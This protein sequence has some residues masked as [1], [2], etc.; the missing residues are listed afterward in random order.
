[1]KANNA[2]Y[3]PA[4][5]GGPAK[6]EVHVPEASFKNNPVAFYSPEAIAPMVLRAVRNNRPFIFDHGD[7]RKAF[8]DTYSQVV[9]A[10]YDDVDAYE[11]EVGI[12]DVVRHVGE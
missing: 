12:P 10:C 8:R 5:F 3:R 6:G 2:S 1:M 7:Q 4:R 9:E 11:R